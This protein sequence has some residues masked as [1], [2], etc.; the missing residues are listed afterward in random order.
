MLQTRDGPRTKYL[1]THLSW[2]TRLPLDSFDFFSQ[3]ALF[4]GQALVIFGHLTVVLR[5]GFVVARQILC[6]R[7]ASRIASTRS[8]SRFS[9]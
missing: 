9:E 4:D 5:E 8:L 3:R 6:W 1:R 2:G 7:N